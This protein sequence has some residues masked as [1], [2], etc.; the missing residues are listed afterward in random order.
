MVSFGLSFVVGVSVGI[1]NSSASPTRYVVRYV[2]TTG[3]DVG[4]CS[5]TPCRHIYY[6]IGQS[7]SR[8]IIMVAA[9][10]Y[11]EQDVIDRDISIQGSGAARTIIDGFLSGPVITIG[12][13]SRSLSVRISDIKI[14][15][16][17]SGIG[18][19]IS[20]T[21]GPGGSNAVSLMQVIIAHNQGV[22]GPSPATTSASGAGIYNGAGS[23][24]SVIG[25]VVRYN[26]AGGAPAH[27]HPAGSGAGGGIYNAGTISITRST[28]SDNTAAGGD[29]CFSG[30][31]GGSGSGGGIY[32]L[33]SLTMVES[34]V[35]GNVAKGGDPGGTA[36]GGGIFGGGDLVNSTVAGNSVLGT[37]PS[38]GGVEA[39]G[40]L[41]VTNSTVA[42]NRAAGGSGGGINVVTHSATFTNAI[43]AANTAATGPDCLGTAVSGGHNLVMNA[44]DCEG[45]TG[46][47]DLQ[48]V[49]PLLG[50]LQDN[51]GRTE[52]MALL[53]GSPA[54]DSADDA[55]CT[56]APVYATDQRLEPRP[57]G[58]H[59]DIGAYELQTLPSG[60]WPRGSG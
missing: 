29:G 46:P 58:P 4:D 25:S 32:N 20:S 28:V 11:T 9:G 7:K 2:A 14:Q 54:I 35:S 8:D 55:V 39:T 31:C 49:D 52:T 47:G 10:M 37:T 17:E 27:D 22:P 41:D 51:G 21:P 40:K 59:C 45:F 43:L 33:G 57:S 26:S 24:M 15:R 6:A 13:E 19:G 12:A 23:G 44:E 3:S 42:Q 5:A 38:G 50:P 53:S 16:G 60:V 1:A 48:G 36:K 34:T 56:G 18:A 30:S